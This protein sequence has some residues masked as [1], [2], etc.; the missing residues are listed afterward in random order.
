MPRPSLVGY[1]NVLRECHFVTDCEQNY[2]PD[3]AIE[4]DMEPDDAP[5][6]ADVYDEIAESYAEGY[7]GSNPYQAELEFP[8]TTALIPDVEGKRVL[9]AG[10]GTGV[11][12]K[13]LLDRG[14]NVVGVD[15]SEEILAQAE[16]L[17]GDRAEFHQAD[18]ET[19]LE[20]ADDDA[21]DGVVCGS[22]LGH[23]EDWRGVFAEFARVLE[24]GGFVVFSVRHPVKNAR[25]LE[26]WTYHD[27]EFKLIDWGIDTPHYARPFSEMVNPLLET[28]FRLKTVDA[29]RPTEAFERKASTE[30]YE[31]LLENPHFLC[32]RAVNE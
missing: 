9:D 1:K 11:Y 10:C 3:E 4:P 13:W 7:W 12:T 14:A 2:T 20:F 31:H 18:L 19:G 24:P 5:T 27:V 15:V 22:V 6:P 21:F 23:V 26:D 28:G 8:S 25:T 32:V 17:V 29:P 16:E 30:E